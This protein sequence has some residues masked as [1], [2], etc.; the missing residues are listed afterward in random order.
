MCLKSQTYFI[1]FPQ[2]IRFVKSVIYTN[3]NKLCY[4]YVVSAIFS[5]SFSLDLSCLPVLNLRGHQNPRTWFTHSIFVRN[6]NI[7]EQIKVQARLR[8][9]DWLYLDPF[10]SVIWSP[11]SL[12][13]SVFQ[14]KLDIFISAPTW[15]PVCLDLQGYSSDGSIYRCF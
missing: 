5:S 12:P 2:I 14:S 4:V 6:F 13:C 1:N 10:T 11:I 8:L 9:K 3:L 15:P 7:T